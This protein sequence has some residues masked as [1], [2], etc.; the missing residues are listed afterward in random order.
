MVRDL[1]VDSQ[2]FAIGDCS[3]FI[4]ASKRNCLNLLSIYRDKKALVKGAALVIND[5]QSFP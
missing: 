2:H 5:L 4:T 3:T 1:L